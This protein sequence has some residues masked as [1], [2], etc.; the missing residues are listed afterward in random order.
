MGLYLLAGE[1]ASLGPNATVL[2]ARVVEA[3]EAAA[4]RGADITL[5]DASE[6][7]KGG[8]VLPSP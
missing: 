1:A 2:G 3:E 5:C 6:L 7:R 8:F 4:L